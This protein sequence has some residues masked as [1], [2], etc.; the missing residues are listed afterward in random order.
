VTEVC[1]LALIAWSTVVLERE[2]RSK[3]HQNPKLN[4]HQILRGRSK[5]FIG[6]LIDG[7]FSLRICLRKHLF[8]ILGFDERFLL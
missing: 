1:G 2:L 5:H 6:M 4:L 8:G 7:F 3:C